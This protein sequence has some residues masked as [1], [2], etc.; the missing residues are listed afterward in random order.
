MNNII[1]SW[2]NKTIRFRASDNYGCLTDMANATGKKVN[3]WTKTQQAKDYIEALSKLT[4]SPAGLLLETTNEGNQED[5]GTWAHPEI[6]EKFWQWC[7]KGKNKQTEKFVSD[8]LAIKLNGLREVPVVCGKVDVLTESNLIEVKSVKNWIEAVGQVLIY[9]QDYPK[10]QKTIH[11]FGECSDNLKHQ[12]I[13]YCF[14]L[15]ITITF[16]QE[17]HE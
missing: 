6:S 3:D 2:N 10:H 4:S 17:S 11:L 9:G 13:S 12:I 1:R 16:E 14:A 7:C 5:K 8:N 15:N